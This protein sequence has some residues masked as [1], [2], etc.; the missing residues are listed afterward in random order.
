[1]YTLYTLSHHYESFQLYF[2]NPK[3][4]FPTKKSIYLIIWS[5]KLLKF[6]KVCPV[7]L[8]SRSFAWNRCG[9][10]TSAGDRWLLQ[11]GASPTL[12]YNTMENW[13]STYTAI[14][15]IYLNYWNFAWFEWQKLLGWVLFSISW[16]WVSNPWIKWGSQNIALLPTPQV[17]VAGKSRWSL[18]LPTHMTN[19][20]GGWFQRYFEWS[21]W[22]V[23]FCGIWLI[24]PKTMERMGLTRWQSIHMRSMVSS[25]FSPHHPNVD[26]S[27]WMSKQQLGAW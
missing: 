2:K 25:K 13:A 8:L 5:L 7:H 20:Y 19:F 10:G 9:A 26:V 15:Q 6:L 14:H 21:P 23:D 27:V 16:R 11:H 1:M 3:S 4:S 17:K 18:N 24:V 12:R 22:S